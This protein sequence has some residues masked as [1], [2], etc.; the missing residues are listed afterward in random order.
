M[1]V[2]LLQTRRV[3][4]FVGAHV[5]NDSGWEVAVDLV[6]GSRPLVFAATFGWGWDARV[7][8]RPWP[9]AWWRRRTPRGNVTTGVAWL[10]LFANVGTM[11]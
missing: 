10:G 1:I 8:L 3:I 9:Q 2:R 4:A 7:P 11:G 5:G 6:L